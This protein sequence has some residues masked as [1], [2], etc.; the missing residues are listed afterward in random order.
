MKRL[1][2]TPSFVAIAL[3]E[4][5]SR[6]PPQSTTDTFIDE[7]ITLVR[8][9]TNYEALFRTLCYTRFQLKLLQ[10]T[11]HTENEMGEK[12]IRIAFRH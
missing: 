10:E 4:A 2:N 3:G 11:C 8:N 9:G 6:Y 12:C 7:I 5:Q 1:V